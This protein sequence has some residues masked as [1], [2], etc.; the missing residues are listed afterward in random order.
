MDLGSGGWGGFLLNFTPIGNGDACQTDT[1][2]EVCTAIRRD[3]A[4]YNLE[5]TMLGILKY[6]AEKQY[7]KKH[8]KPKELDPIATLVLT[9]IMPLVF[10]IVGI[11]KLIAMLRADT[12]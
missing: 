2:I 7:E 5:V 11:L 4:S 12:P 9:V 3:W 6:L 8:G 10:L 1:P